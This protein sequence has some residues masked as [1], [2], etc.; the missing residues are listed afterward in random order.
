M[1]GEGPVVGQTTAAV[2]A[3]RQRE[4]ETD[5]NYGVTLR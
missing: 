5:A 3:M 2:L 1:T 4:Y